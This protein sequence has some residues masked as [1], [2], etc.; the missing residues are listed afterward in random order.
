[1]RGQAGSIPRALG[2]RIAELCAAAD[3]RELRLAVLGELRRAI[4]FD[5]YTWLLA[6]RAAPTA[7]S[8]AEP[9]RRFISRSGRPGAVGTEL[10]EPSHH[11]HIFRIWPA[12]IFSCLD[13]GG[14][15]GE[16][17]RARRGM[18]LAGAGHIG[19]APRLL[20]IHWPD[21]VSCVIRGT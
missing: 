3:A 1:V 19:L 17:V 21:G 5:A 14:R 18:P 10:W 4:G 9:G 11:L 8:L 16:M 15:G 2:R 7:A 13:G 12:Q 6:N 20:S